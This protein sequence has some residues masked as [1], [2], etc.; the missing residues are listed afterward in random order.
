MSFLFFFPMA[1]LLTFFPRDEKGL[2]ENIITFLILLRRL[3]FQR[4][5][6]TDNENF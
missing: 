2:K 4:K 3:L 5:C 1:L 6:F